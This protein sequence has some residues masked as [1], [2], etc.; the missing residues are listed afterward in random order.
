MNKYKNYYIGKQVSFTKAFPTKCSQRFPTVFDESTFE[1][2]GRSKEAFPIE[3]LHGQG[4]IIGIKM[5]IMSNY[6]YT[7]ETS[8]QGFEDQY[9]DVVQACSSGKREQCLLVVKGIKGKANKPFLVRYVD[10]PIE[11]ILFP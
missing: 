8:T 9:P 5:A 3:G 1:S 10:L 11:K 4:Y 6:T 2:V 7:E